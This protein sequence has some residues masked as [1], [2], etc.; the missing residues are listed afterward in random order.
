MS[1]TNVLL[2]IPVATCLLVCEKTMKMNIEN[3]THNT[4][5][6]DSQRFGNS[7]LNTLFKN[8]LW[9]EARMSH[10]QYPINLDQMCR[11]AHV[12]GSFT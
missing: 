12:K 10:S 2:L 6:F 7:K 11:M 1:Q 8:K 4:T 9:C 3:I 5:K